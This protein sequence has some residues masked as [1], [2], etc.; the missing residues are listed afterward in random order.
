MT[1]IKYSLIP[2]FCLLLLNCS[3][4]SDDKQKGIDIALETSKANPTNKKSSPP[5]EGKSLSSGR[6]IS[7]NALYDW[8]QFFKASP[9]ME[10]REAIEQDLKQNPKTYNQKQ[11]LQKARKQTALGH[12]QQAELNYRQ[13]IRQNPKH[14]DAKLELAMIAIHKHDLNQASRLL[15]EL[16]KDMKKKE[17]IKKTFQFRYQYT[18]ALI[19]LQK[20]R[21][22]SAHRILSDLIALDPQFIP[23]Y[24]ALASSY[25]EE[26]KLDVAEFVV[27]RGIDRGGEHANLLNLLG[28]IAEEYGFYDK[29]RYWYDKALE[30]SDSFAPALINKGIV[31]VK[32]FRYEKARH[33]L[34]KSLKL[35]PHNVE[36]HIILGI[37]YQKMRNFRAAK[38]TLENAL[39]L[40]PH[41]PE[42]RYNLALL[43][44]DGF[45]SPDEAIRLFYEVIQSPQANQELKDI[46]NSYVNDIKN[47]RGTF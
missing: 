13:I 19:H 47:N 15:N 35:Q 5:K 32:H 44:M 39:A 43:L 12:F 30:K 36:A 41:N 33:F 29:A 46:S 6:R 27:K 7:N 37:V 18:L 31:A 4:S 20:K 9:S 26:Q 14:I 8:H 24:A 42:T 1:K 2:C 45:K 34:L 11:S 3:V 21:R 22:S 23:G 25:I 38:T 16:S 17:V 28:V 40:D 10:Q